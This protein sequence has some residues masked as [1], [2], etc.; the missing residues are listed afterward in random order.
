MIKKSDLQIILPTSFGGNSN[1]QKKK[2]KENLE[3]LK[4]NLKL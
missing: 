2:R 1:A 4:K 3:L